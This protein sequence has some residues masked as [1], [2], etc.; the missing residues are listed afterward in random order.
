VRLSSPADL[1]AV[2]DALTPDAYA[3]LRAQLD[4]APSTTFSADAD[5][6]RGLVAAVAGRA[7]PLRVAT[8]KLVA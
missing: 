7:A 2:L 6:C 3:G 8:A 4:A 5:D 1:E